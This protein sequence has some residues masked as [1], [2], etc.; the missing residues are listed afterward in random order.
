[1]DCL[2][3]GDLHIRVVALANHTT[4]KI[5]SEA[6]WI[7]CNMI[8]VANDVQLATLLS[9]EAISCLIDGLQLQNPEI[10]NVLIST[11]EK[12]VNRVEFESYREQLAEELQALNMEDE[13]INGMLAFIEMND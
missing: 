13:R 6:L 5:R 9:S 12:I 3:K 4:E 10:T 2:L 8:S 7:L 11:Y 1:M